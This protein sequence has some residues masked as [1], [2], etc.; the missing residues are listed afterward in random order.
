VTVVPLVVIER[1]S[2][3]AVVVDRPFRDAFVEVGA[4]SGGWRRSG[5]GGEAAVGVE[6]VGG[7]GP[8]LGE[9]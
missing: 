5:D 8:L 4:A 1:M 6:E 3:G 9:A 2:H 7:P